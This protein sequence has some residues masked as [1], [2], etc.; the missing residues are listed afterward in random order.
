[1]AMGLRKKRGRP[2][3]LWT[4]TAS[5][6]VGANHPFCQRLSQILDKKKF[7]EYVEIIGEDF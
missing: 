1:M 2:E 7:D 3:G 6:Q 4:A 5:L